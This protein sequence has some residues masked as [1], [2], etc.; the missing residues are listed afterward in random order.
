M[1]VNIK[2]C[3]PVTIKMFTILSLLLLLLLPEFDRVYL[4]FLESLQ[5]LAD[6]ERVPVHETVLGATASSSIRQF[7]LHSNV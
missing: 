1:Y 3:F 4:L 5:P 2:Q 7:Y 6:E